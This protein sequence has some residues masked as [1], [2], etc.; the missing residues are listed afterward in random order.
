MAG[1]QR[2]L[3]SAIDVTGGTPP[4]DDAGE[5]PERRRDNLDGN[6]LTPTDTSGTDSATVAASRSPP[7]T[8][9]LQPRRSEAQSST[10]TDLQSSIAK[11]LEA[12]NAAEL[13]GAPASE[14]EIRQ[15]QVDRAVEILQRTRGGNTSGEARPA[16][17]EAGRIMRV[18]NNVQPKPRLGGEHKPPTPQ[19]VDQWVKD[20]DTAFQYAQVLTDSITRTHWIMGTI[21][22]GTHRELIQQRI[23]EGSIRTWANLRAEEE[24]MVQDPVFTR[25]ENYQKFFRFEWKQDDTV[26]GFLMKLNKVESLLPRSFSKFDDGTEDHEFRIAFVWSRTPLALQREIQRNGVLEHLKEWGEFERA[27]RNAETAVGSVTQYSRK[28]E[29]APKSKRGP[30][31]P[32]RSRFKRQN[33]RNTTPARNEPGKSPTDSQNRFQSFG[34]TQNGSRW[35]PQNGGDQTNS[36]GNQKPHWRNRNPKGDD[37]QRQ[38][39]SGKAKS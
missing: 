2:V 38:Q 6:E 26:N 11:L 31:S 24:Q 35:K 32:P 30:S 18:L 5:R 4:R 33:S 29:Q 8:L 9:P 23:N 20:V 3:R 15:R 1:G 21:Q 13:S 39:G 16:F 10:A 37:Q 36:D 25:Y 28:E 7:T 17:D 22:F 14:I 12:L 19:Q 27:L 34:A